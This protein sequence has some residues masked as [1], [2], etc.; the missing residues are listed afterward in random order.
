MVG[1]LLHNTPVYCSIHWSSAHD[2]EGGH[3]MGDIIGRS[4]SLHHRVSTVKGI[5]VVHRLE[6]EDTIGSR[7]TRCCSV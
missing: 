6:G 7:T 5:S 4:K 3:D 1:W 2:D